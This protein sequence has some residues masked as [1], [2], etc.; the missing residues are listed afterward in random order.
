MTQHDAQKFLER[1]KSRRRQMIALSLRTVREG[2][3]PVTLGLDPPEGF[4]PHCHSCPSEE[5]MTPTT[6]GWRCTSCGM[7]VDRNL[8]PLHG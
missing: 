5:L 1:A 8:A 7:E 2:K 6:Y 3:R 4:K